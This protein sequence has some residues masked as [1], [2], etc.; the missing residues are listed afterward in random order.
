MENVKQGNGDSR[1]LKMVKWSLTLVLCLTLIGLVAIVVMPIEK[2]A[3]VGTLVAAAL[4]VVGVISG[5]YTGIQGYADSRAVSRPYGGGGHGR[6]HQ[7]YP[8]QYPPPTLPP[9]GGDIEEAV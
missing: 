3:S 7:P 5:T 1:K 8:P 2:V 6:P 4:A 9:I